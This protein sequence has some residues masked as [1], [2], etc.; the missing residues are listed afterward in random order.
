MGVDADPTTAQGVYPVVLGVIGP[1]G[2]PAGGYTYVPA[3]SF[4]T[5]GNGN[6]Y[7]TLTDT[8][9][10]MG[11]ENGQW[12]YGNRDLAANWGSTT[13]VNYCFKYYALTGVPHPSV[14]FLN[15]QFCPAGDA[16]LILSNLTSGNNV[17]LGE[18]VFGMWIG[19]V[20]PN[21]VVDSLY[22]A[23][24]NEVNGSGGDSNTVCYKVDNAGTFP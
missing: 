18:T 22:G 8:A 5:S 10:V 17:Y 14:Q 19:A 2:C 13:N 6:T 3:T 11:G 20:N 9:S 23:T 24:T 12:N 1:A 4:A 21:Q 15:G 7:L 16:S